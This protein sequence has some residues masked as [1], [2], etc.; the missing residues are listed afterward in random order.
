MQWLGLS[1]C[2]FCDKLVNIAIT[3]TSCNFRQTTIPHFVFTKDNSIHQMLRVEG[4]TL[5]QLPLWNQIGRLTVEEMQHV[6]FEASWERFP[7]LQISTFCQFFAKSRSSEV[8]LGDFELAKSWPYF[9]L[10]GTCAKWTCHL[11]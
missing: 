11:N 7:R 9:F 1:S 6:D 5:M 2:L 4:P 3:I 8:S 10:E